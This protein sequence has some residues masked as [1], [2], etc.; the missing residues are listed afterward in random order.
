MECYRCGTQA[1]SLEM[2][3]L[4]GTSE[5]Q[6]AGQVSGTGYSLGGGFGHYTGKVH[7]TSF[8]QTYLATLAAPPPRPRLGSMFWACLT[9]NLLFCVYIFALLIAPKL[10][11]LN[12]PQAA[13]MM[14]SISFLCLV[15]ALVAKVAFDLRFY[16]FVMAFFLT[17]LALI[18]FAI[19]DIYK[20]AADRQTYS[21]R[22]AQWRNSFMCTGCGEQLTR[23]AVV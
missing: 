21:Q 6:I 8:N 16:H 1:V 20:Y 7:G 5:N 13:V 10:F 15:V 14:V 17:P 19:L 22:L 23:F 18:P 4:S 2:A 3:Y 9:L 11:N 12:A